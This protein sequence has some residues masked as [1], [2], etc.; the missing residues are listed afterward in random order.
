MS[1]LISCSL[2][3]SEI[4]FFHLFGTAPTI[5]LSRISKQIYDK[6]KLSRILWYCGCSPKEM[7]KPYF[8]VWE[9]A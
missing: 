1:F 3:Y 6:S 7:E 5:P 4:R 8:R 2:P 9:A